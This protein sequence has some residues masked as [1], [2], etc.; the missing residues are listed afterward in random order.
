MGIWK[1]S[2]TAGK[3]K[4]GFNAETQSA[5]AGVANVFMR[6]TSP[7][8]SPPPKRGG[9]GENPVI[10]R[11]VAKPRFWIWGQQDAYFMVILA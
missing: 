10:V 11:F 3:R 7:R 8:P 2:E 6:T 5:G 4:R 9:E 1:K